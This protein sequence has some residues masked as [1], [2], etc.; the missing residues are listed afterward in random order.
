MTGE[1]EDAGERGGDNM[2]K[3]ST[4]RGKGIGAHLDTMLLFST[5]WRNYPGGKRP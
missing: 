4:D 1:S 2:R 3:I 5:L